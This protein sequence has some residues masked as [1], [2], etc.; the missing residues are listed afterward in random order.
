MRTMVLMRAKE[1]VQWEEGRGRSEA[2][3]IRLL[4]TTLVTWSDV[5]DKQHLK[6]IGE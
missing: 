3:F 2:T 5:K 4:S 6:V 1:Q